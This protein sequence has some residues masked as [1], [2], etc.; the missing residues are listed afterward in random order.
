MTQ[1]VREIR[2]HC[3]KVGV[4]TPVKSASLGLKQTSG[5]IFFLFFVSLIVS[6]FVVVV[7][8]VVGWWW[9]YGVVVVSIL[10]RPEGKRKRVGHAAMYG[11]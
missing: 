10:N 1:E 2:R 4:N 11:A 8:V 6:F 3:D 7:V 9:W 5:V